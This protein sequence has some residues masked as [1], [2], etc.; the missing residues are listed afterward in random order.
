MF[1]FTSILLSIISCNCVTFNL[2]YLGYYNNTYNI[3]NTIGLNLNSSLERYLGYINYTNY[4]EP[5]YITIEYLAKHI[6]H[7][8]LHLSNEETRIVDYRNINNVNYI[9]PI[10]YQ[11]NCGACVSFAAISVLETQY[12]LNGITLDLSEKDL[13]FCKGRRNCNEGWYLYDVS[14]VLKYN[15]ISEEKYCPYFENA[16]KCTDSCNM[17]SLYKIKDFYYINNFNDIKIW[18]DRNGTLLTRMNVYRDFFNYNGGIYQ[19]NS[20]VYIGGHA[21]DNNK[22]QYWICKNSWGE[23]WGENG[24]FKIKYGE[25]GIMPYAYGYTIDTSQNHTVINNA[26]TY[27]PCLILYLLIL[28]LF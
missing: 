15:E 28:N 1:I 26:R 9:T 10:K 8:G 5:D 22:E 13:F 2:Y 27:T 20:D 14:I 19:K 18:L 4:N 7:T 16:F 3:D 25:S 6:L 21:I 23:Q 12:K 24:F 17:Y 11:H